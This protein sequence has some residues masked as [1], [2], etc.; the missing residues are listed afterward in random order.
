MVINGLNEIPLYLGNANGT[1]IETEG[2]K[3]QWWARHEA[4]L[5]NWSSVVKNILLVKPSSVSA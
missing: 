4:I 2:N 3:V 1:K 5:S